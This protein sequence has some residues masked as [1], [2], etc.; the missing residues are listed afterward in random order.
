MRYLLYRIIYI[1]RLPSKHNKNYRV[2]EDP[3]LFSVNV[4]TWAFKTFDMK[5][6]WERFSIDQKALIK[7]H[8]DIGTKGFPKFLETYKPIQNDN[9]MFRAVVRAREMAWILKEKDIN[10]NI[11]EFVD[12]SNCWKI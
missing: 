10:L 5:S 11:D 3:T 1:M 8:F 12:Y 6:P 4:F 2:W 9:G 7:V